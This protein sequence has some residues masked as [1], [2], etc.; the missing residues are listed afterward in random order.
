M[1]LIY[2]CVCVR[3]CM[4]DIYIYIVVTFYSPRSSMWREEAVEFKL[5]FVGLFKCAIKTTLA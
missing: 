4:Y 2:M 1:I 5:L 3:I